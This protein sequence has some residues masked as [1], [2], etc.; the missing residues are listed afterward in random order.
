MN[1]TILRGMLLFIPLLSLN[2]CYLAKQG[3]YTA[4]YT[5]SAR[6]IEKTLQKEMVDDSL[7]ALFEKVRSIKKYSVEKIGLVENKNYTRYISIEKKYL[8]DLLAASPPDSFSLHTWWFPFFGR[9]PYLGYFK[10]GDA[11]RE[12]KKFKK[13]GLEVIILPVDAFSTLGIV[14]DPVY[15]FMKKLSLFQLSSLIFHEQTHATVF[16]KN[17]M[18]FNEECATFVGE[19]GALSFIRDRFGDTSAA[20]RNALLEKEDGDTWDRVLREL[21]GSLDSV[22]SGKS[23]REEKLRRKKQIIDSFKQSMSE[24]SHDLFKT[25]L[26][27]RVPNIPI[28][29][30][31]LAVRMTYCKDLSL[32]YGLYGNKENNLHATIEELKKLKKLN[33]KDPKEYLRR[34]LRQADEARS[35]SGGFTDSLLSKGD[36]IIPGFSADEQRA[37]IVHETR[38][39]RLPHFLV[40]GQD[41]CSLPA[42]SQEIFIKRLVTIERRHK[43]ELF[44]C[45]VAG[46][47]GNTETAL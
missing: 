18:N 21:H 28:N 39:V 35:Q 30:A 16:L 45:V 31:Y 15:T 42:D 7:K 43:G 9:A 20:Y 23:S 26:Y 32:M 27:K 25:D 12:A 47:E 37:L 10:T 33:P 46:P 34:M 1:V 13:K 40:R 6:S 19:T 44:R 36:E 5:F 24:N 41:A 11:I 22:Y 2:C 17:Q 3:F 8:I 38:P 14:S 29:N 4:K